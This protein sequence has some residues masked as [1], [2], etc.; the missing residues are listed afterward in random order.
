MARFMRARLTVA[1]VAGLLPLAAQSQAIR[2]AP[3]A[4][5][6]MRQQS[7]SALST[8]LRRKGMLRPAQG[9][10]PASVASLV[11]FRGNT[12]DVTSVGGRIVWRLGDV[13]EVSVPLGE[14]ASLAKLPAVRYVDLAMPLVPQLDVAVPA[15]GATQMR[16]GTPPEWRGDTGRNV[17]IGILDTGI[18]LAHP[19]FLDP[20]GTTRILH[21]FDYT[22]G[23]Q[24]TAA[25]INAHECTEVDTDGHG[26]QVAGIAAGNGAATGNGELAYRY[27]GMAPEAD[28]IVAK[29]D[30]TTANIVQA[31]GDME[32]LAAPLGLPLVI[33]MSLGTE[34][35]P[36]DGTDNAAR[37]L[38]N[39]SGPGRIIVI[40]A[41]NHAADGTHASGTVTQDGSIVTNLDV[42]VSTDLTL[43]DIWYGG[44]DQL[45]VHLHNT[46]ECDSGLIS[47]PVA[48]SSAESSF[49]SGRGTVVSGG[50]NPLNGDRE[51]LVTLAATPTTPFAATAWTLELRGTAVANG[52]FDAWVNGTSSGAKFTSNLDASDTL[53]D[54]AAAT[55]PIAVGAYN[56]K[57]TWYSLEGPMSAEVSNPLGMLASYSSHGPRRACSAAASCPAVQKPEITAPGAW[58]A[59]AYSAQT[60][61]PDGTCSDCYIDLDGVHSFRQGT[62]MA[63]P[64]VSGAVA[65]LLQVD[66]AG[67][68]TQIRDLLEQYAKVDDFVG[69][70]PNVT[71]GYGKLD[72]KAA[73]DALP[74]P[75]PPAPAGVSATVSGSSTVLAWSPS[76]ALDVDGY[77]IYR[78]TSSGDLAQVASVSYKS[79]TYTDAGLSS[80]TYYYVVRTL[81]TKEQESLPSAQV[82]AVIGSS[83]ST[84]T[85][86]SGGGGGLDDPSLA[87]LF[88]LVTLSALRRGRRGGQRGNAGESR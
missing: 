6:I 56:T 88:L 65:L 69:Q 40:A 30:W 58:I 45:A 66:P 16:S 4:T 85:S 57:N 46:A 72:V 39:A 19:D 78:G 23:T 49:C 83:S 55:A 5:A 33:N 32:N 84:A 86:S 22:T 11:R 1:I 73:F 41:G 35:G 27:V 60:Q 24:C 53:N 59:S 28:L 13:A 12:L 26:T 61:W 21:L 68:P 74:V 43:I 14:L 77:D 82:S 20:A 79:A 64:M 9:S 18:D 63:A 42:P 34:I 50:I 38:D 37:A 15:T 36:H 76:S 75:L 7:R 44:A 54:L 52:R 62:S 47:A 8:V 10:Q 48:D 29:A 3:L 80:G 67:D 51:I 70:A 25:Q 17:I 81:D 87:A 71:W 31:V 2:L